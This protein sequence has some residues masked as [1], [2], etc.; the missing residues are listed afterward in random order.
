MAKVKYSDKLIGLKC[1]IC[2][3]RNYY[4]RKNKK[5]VERKIQLVKYCGWCRKRSAH[6]ETKL[7]GK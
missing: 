2:N 1:S 3:R 6:K 7:T 4:T 5:S